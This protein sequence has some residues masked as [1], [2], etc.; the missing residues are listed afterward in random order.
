MRYIVWFMQF[1][2]R[3]GTLFLSHKGFT[4]GV[5]LDLQIVVDAPKRRISPPVVGCSRGCE[6]TSPV[7]K[8]LERFEF[9]HWGDLNAFYESM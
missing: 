9:I 6:I 4:W 8:T 2:M 1:L 3:I 5:G 7:S